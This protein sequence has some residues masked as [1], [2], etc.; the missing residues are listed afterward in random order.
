[1]LGIVII[2][3]DE[4]AAQRLEAEIG[5]VAVILYV[6][7][8]FLRVSLLIRSHAKGRCM[9]VKEWSLT[10]Y[11]WHFPAFAVNDS[12]I[13]AQVLL[14]DFFTDSAAT[15]TDWRAVLLAQHDG[16]VFDERKHSILQSELKSFYVGLTRARERVWI[17]DRSLN[18]KDM[19]V[20][21]SGGYGTGATG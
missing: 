8:R 21:A 7:E 3:R 2:V 10:T 4:N 15:P 12:E 13:I 18:G 14:Y 20:R 5:R 6:P 11:V 16:R 17:W 1:M 9:R 19:E